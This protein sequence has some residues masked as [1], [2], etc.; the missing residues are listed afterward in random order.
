MPLRPN[1][2]T[3]QFS[4]RRK[5]NLMHTPEIRPILWFCNELGPHRILANVLPLLRVTFVVAQSVVKTAGLKFPK[6]VAGRRRRVALILQR[7]CQPVFPETHPAFDGEFQITRRAEQMQM[8]RHQEIV[9]HQPRR[10][11]V[12]PDVVQGAL[13]GSLRQP[14][15]PPKQY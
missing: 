13:H 5:M 7:L 12:L 14:A 3:P 9:A 1:Y 8:I 6:H 2:S 10:R 15:T 11:R 4:I